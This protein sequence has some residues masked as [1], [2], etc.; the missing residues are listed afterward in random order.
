MKEP[1]P[2]P[3]VSHH[4]PRGAGH[5]LK[6]ETMRIIQSNILLALAGLALVG[7]LYT[8]SASLNPGLLVGGL[9]EEVDI[10]DLQAAIA[11][12]TKADLQ[13]VY[14]NL[15]NASENHLSAFAKVIE[16]QH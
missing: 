11:G 8:G 14:G 6:A 13:Q 2:V 1:R 9:I 12:T 16:A 4:G 5:N 10:E 15:M 7:T 3:P